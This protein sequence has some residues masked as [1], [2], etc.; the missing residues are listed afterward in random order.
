[1]LVVIAPL[2]REA[3]RTW[4]GLDSPS[5]VGRARESGWSPDDRDAYCWRCG[6]GVGAGEVDGDGCASCRTKR[7]AWERALRLGAYRGELADMIRE[8]K[9]TGRRRLASELGRLLGARLADELRR[10]GVAPDEAVLVPVPMSWA[11][12]MD[13]GIDHTLAIARGVRGSSGLPIV[14]ALRRRHGPSQ[15]EVPPSRRR[16]NVR[17]VFVPR[18][19]AEG[20]EGRSVVLLDDV[21]TTGA[22]LTSAARALRGTGGVDRVWAAVLAVTPRDG[23]T[24]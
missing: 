11:Q 10:A 22:T 9:F 4:L 14:R 7:P 15:L 6:S 13:R 17:G 12:R 18:K 20:L 19:P 5:L 1:M 16:A 24:T 8:I 21:R 3:E 23:R 2:L